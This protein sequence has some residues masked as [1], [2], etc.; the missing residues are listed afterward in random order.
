MRNL[1]LSKKEVKVELM[2]NL[3]S[4]IY[5]TIFGFKKWQFIVVLI[6]EPIWL[7]V[8]DEFSCKQLFFCEKFHHSWYK[9]AGVVNF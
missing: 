6:L 2:K 3:N 1:E 5:K 4:C 8:V 9:I 7:K